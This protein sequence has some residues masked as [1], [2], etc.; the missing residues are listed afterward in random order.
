MTQ[1]RSSYFSIQSKLHAPDTVEVYYYPGESLRHYFGHVAIRHAQARDRSDYLTYFPG[2]GKVDEQWRLPYL[3]LSTAEPNKTELDQNYREKI[4][5]VI[6][7]G[8]DIFIYGVNAEGNTELTQS[9]S[10]ALYKK[11][12]F[13][14]Q[15][16]QPNEL[17]NEIFEDVRLLC[18]YADAAQRALEEKEI[19]GGV[20]KISL[21]SHPNAQLRSAREE[22]LQ[23]DCER[24]TLLKNNCANAV[25]NY[26]VTAGYVSA[27][28]DFIQTLARE[29]KELE[30]Q[31][32]ALEKQIEILS[33]RKKQIE[34]E[35]K[36]SVFSAS[37]K[38]SLAAEKVLLQSE[39]EKWQEKI[40]QMRA[41]MVDEFKPSDLETWGLKP[42]TVAL[43]S[44]EIVAMDLA[45]QRASILE[46]KLTNPEK[47]QQL[48][49]NDIKKLELQMLMERVKTKNV[50]AKE[51]PTL[52]VLKEKIADLTALAS[53]DENALFV[54]TYAKQKF[55]KE[56]IDGQPQMT[57]SIPEL[58]EY[59]FAKAELSQGNYYPIQTLYQTT[60]SALQ[61][62][63]I[64]YA[65]VLQHAL[66]I[67]KA[68]MVVEPMVEEPM[69]DTRPRRGAVS[70]SPL[71]RT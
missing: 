59:A 29:A 13:T 58:R 42:Q 30:S 65:Q 33:A 53:L 70:I 32:S 41:K 16:T 18:P 40:A 24:H 10:P 50:D 47:F 7:Y 6:K 48:L 67:F 26:L 31:I 20:I 69:M 43:L 62:E 35:E 38:P 49:L 15:A 9:G 51:T 27:H 3:L 14:L 52:A 45:R 68:E 55:L 34:E 17:D 4:P 36:I 21:P 19:Y 2:N 5:L 60:R 57:R 44:C 54:D 11:V 23:L 66:P 25:A 39:I 28:N 46:Q 37:D 8:E 12:K 1:S 56:L 61:Q 71:K 63:P 22:F 64:K